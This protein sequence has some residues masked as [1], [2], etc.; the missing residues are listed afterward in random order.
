MSGPMSVELGGDLLGYR[1]P[2]TP[3]EHR[4]IEELKALVER[5]EQGGALYNWNL[6]HEALQE[7]QWLDP[8]IIVTPEQLAAGRLDYLVEQAH[9]RIEM[10][11]AG[12]FEAGVELSRLIR[13]PHNP[14]TFELAGVTQFQVDNWYIQAQGHLP[15]GISDDCSRQLHP[16]CFHPE[17]TCPHHLDPDWGSAL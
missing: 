9:L 10:C 16:I 11:H 15:L 12:M 17:C 1:E 4:L 13:D 14:L 3:A 5:A 2:K 8:A 6:V 7:A